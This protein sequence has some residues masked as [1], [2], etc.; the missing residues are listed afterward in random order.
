MRA[1]TPIIVFPLHAQGAPSFRAVLKGMDPL[2]SVPLLTLA[3]SGGLVANK[4]GGNANLVINTGLG[5]TSGALAGFCMAY[6][7]SAARIDGHIQ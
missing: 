2:D 3:V 7:K 1:P 4:C 6:F 5:I